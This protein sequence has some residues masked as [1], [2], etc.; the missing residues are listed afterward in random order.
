MQH[1]SMSLDGMIC[2][3][4]FTVDMYPLIINVFI[5]MELNIVYKTECVVKQESNARINLL[6]IFHTNEQESLQDVMLLL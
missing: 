2:L 6:Y 3:V 4:L 5:L 1:N